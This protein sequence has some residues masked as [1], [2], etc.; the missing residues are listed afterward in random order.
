M[1]IYELLMLVPEMRNA[2]V[3]A[4]LNPQTYEAQVATFCDNPVET[5]ESNVTFTGQDM[6]LHVNHIRPLFVHGQ[7][8][9]YDRGCGIKRILIDGGSAANIIPLRTVKLLGLSQKHLEQEQVTISGFNSQSQQTLGSI[10]LQLELGTWKTVVMAYVLDADTSYNMLLG[11]TWIHENSVVPST[12]HQCLK[13]EKD[14]REYTHKADLFPFSLNESHLADACYYFDA[15]TAVK[16]AHP[17]KNRDDEPIYFKIPRSS[18]SRT[19]KDKKHRV[20]SRKIVN[21]V[22]TLSI[23]AVQILRTFIVSVGTDDQASI[24]FR[25]GRGQSPA[26]DFPEESS[27]DEEIARI[28]DLNSKVWKIVS[29]GGQPIKQSRRRM[30]LFRSLWS[31]PDS[32]TDPEDKRGLGYTSEES[33]E[34]SEDGESSPDALLDGFRRLTVTNMVSLKS[35]ANSLREVAERDTERGWCPRPS[36]TTR[37]ETSDAERPV[38]NDEAQSSDGEQPL[39]V[40]LKKQNQFTKKG[41]MTIRQLA[42]EVKNVLEKADNYPEVTKVIAELQEYARL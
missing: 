16:S 27:D 8:R 38:S 41:R 11:R 42:E 26:D 15:S 24:V 37:A 33:S 35:L 1:S 5:S 39:Y 13:Y 30:N 9:A 31:N 4:L 40:A 23:D 20:V 29:P 2:L 6:L 18:G 7:V 3:E 19:K 10:T 21:A 32:K 34:E 28:P 25:R 14:G 17:V 12:L 22:R 36:L